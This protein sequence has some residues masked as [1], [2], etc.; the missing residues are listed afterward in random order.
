M[1]TAL[2]QWDD[3]V[4]LLCGGDR[5]RLLALL[6]KWVGSDNAVTKP[7]PCPTV[8]RHH[9]RIT[10]VAFV[11]LGFLLVRSA[12]KRPLGILGQPGWELGRLGRL[13]KQSPPW[14]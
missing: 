9:S 4:N 8:A 7:L 5:A 14:A 1:C 11:P 3:V 10:L 2:G 13:G 6:G 12:Q